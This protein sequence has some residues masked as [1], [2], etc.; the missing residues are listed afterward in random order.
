MGNGDGNL[1]LGRIARADAARGD[2]ANGPCRP[3]RPSGWFYADEPPVMRR[4]SRRKRTV[5]AVFL[6]VPLL[7]TALLVG[8]L[9]RYKGCYVMIRVEE[10]ST[11]ALRAWPVLSEDP[12]QAWADPET[13]TL[14]LTRTKMPWTAIMAVHYSANSLGVRFYDGLSFSSTGRMKLPLTQPISWLVPGENGEMVEG[15]D[16]SARVL[17]GDLRFE[18]CTPQGRVAFK[19]GPARI[20]LEPGESWGILLV[21]DGNG[22]REISGDSWRQELEEAMVRGYPATRLMVTN[23]GLWPKAGVTTVGEGGHGW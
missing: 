3:P 6:G 22:I 19:Y 21:S 12:A 9:A 4:D 13:K 8:N 10:S 17:L 15:V 20:V 23:L 7:V 5:L 14:E 2:G 11:L 1:P 18:G 16:N